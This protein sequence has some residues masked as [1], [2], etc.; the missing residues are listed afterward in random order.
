LYSSSTTSTRF[1]LSSMGQY[2]PLYS[3]ISATAYLQ[4]AIIHH[5]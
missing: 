3:E 1:P 4:H 5:T 2:R